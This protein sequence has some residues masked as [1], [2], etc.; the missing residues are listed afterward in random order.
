MTKKTKKTPSTKQPESVDA[1]FE[2][3]S[4][5]G[6]ERAQAAG[7]RDFDV[8][9]NKYEKEYD[10]AFYELAARGWTPIQIAVQLQVDKEALLS[11][12]TDPKKKSFGRAFKAGRE[13]CQAFHEGLYQQMAQGIV[14][15]SSAE[16]AAQANILKTLFSDDW[17]PVERR[18]VEVTNTV[19]KLSEEE[20]NR[21]LMK[22]LNSDIAKQHLKN[23]G[24]K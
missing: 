12:A 9:S 21:Q 17:N 22:L 16:L 3:C 19:E 6:S 2:Q 18:E 1:P 15:C 7:G 14:K 13:A 5:S 10:S 24:K 20:L 11:W 23:L 4:V 8:W